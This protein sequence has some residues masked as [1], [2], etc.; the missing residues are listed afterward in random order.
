MQGCPPTCADRPLGAL[1]GGWQR[2]VLLARA[3]VTG[4]D[5]LLLDEPTNHL[6][7]GRI[8]AL[9][10]LL[11]ALPRGTAVIAASHDR[12]FL[13][14]VTTRTL[15]LRPERSAL[16]PLPYS[17]ARAALD[18][19]DAA[20]GR[21]F[22]VEMK[23]ARQLR[24]QAAKLHNIGVNSG[25]GPADDEDP[26]AEGARRKDRRLGRGPPISSGRRARSGSATPAP[27]PRR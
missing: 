21:A 2:L 23:K 3:L 16:V 15:F 10:R 9:Q 11:A 12:A 7:L 18:E 27:M 26:A 22:E 20:D 24:Q 17:R 14:A 19:R 6:D 8:G 4:P 13:D 5:L 1:S 25:L